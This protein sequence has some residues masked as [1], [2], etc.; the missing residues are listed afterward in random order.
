MVFGFKTRKQTL[1]RQENIELLKWES[2]MTLV[3]C[4]LA[5]NVFPVSFL[6]MGGWA[7]HLKQW[8]EVAFLAVVPE[9]YV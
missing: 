5:N 6:T 8:N 2:L 4:F 3:L 9:G 1:E 7:M